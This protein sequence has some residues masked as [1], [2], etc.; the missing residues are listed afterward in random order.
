MTRPA[1]GGTVDV[2]VEE[3]QEDAD[4]LPLTGR[5]DAVLGRAGVHHPAV[6]GGEDDVTT[7]LSVVRR[8]VGVAEEGDDPGGEGEQADGGAT[9][10]GEGGGEGRSGTHESGGHRRCVD[11]WGE[12]GHERTA[13]VSRRT[14]HVAAR[15]TACAPACPSG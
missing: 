8:T 1:Y 6:G 15:R 4:L 5:G 9:V 10:S 14:A 11:A 13:Y 12:G 2:H 3:R 7:G